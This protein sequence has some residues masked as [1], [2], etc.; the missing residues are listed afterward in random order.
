M[1]KFNH[2]LPKNRNPKK[3]KKRGEKRKVK[4]KKKTTK[5]HQNKKIGSDANL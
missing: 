4:K 1:R 5:T 2:S 3:E